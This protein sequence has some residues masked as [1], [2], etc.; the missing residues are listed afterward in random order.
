MS[1]TFVGIRPSDTPGFITAQFAGAAA[2]TILF[3]WLASSAP[4]SAVGD[5][6]TREN[7]Q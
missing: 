7:K 1:D 6:A 4:K 2:A 5:A 3:R